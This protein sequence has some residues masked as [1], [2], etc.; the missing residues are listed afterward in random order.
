M[1]EHV[2]LLCHA[3][4][5]SSAA[6]IWFPSRVVSFI[7]T[8]DG[9]NYRWIIILLILIKV[10]IQSEKQMTTAIT[11]LRAVGLLLVLLIV[12]HYAIA[13]ISIDTSQKLFAPNVH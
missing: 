3:D 8:K 5:E 9:L 7:S 11:S 13:M 6:I 4:E 12:I 10:N 1:S 2:Q